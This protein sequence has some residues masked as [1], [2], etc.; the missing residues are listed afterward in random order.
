MRYTALPQPHSTTGFDGEKYRPI[1]A[2]ESRVS[3]EA[4]RRT[5]GNPPLSH[6]HEAPDVSCAN[7]LRRR[8]GARGRVGGSRYLPHDRVRS[9]TER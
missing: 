9:T 2:A 7:D 6:P 8:T 5:L 1:L 4:R 3:L